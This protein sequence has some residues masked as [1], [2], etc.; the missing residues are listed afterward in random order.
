MSNNYF[1]D[2]KQEHDRF[3]MAQ[4]QKYYTFG[5][6]VSISPTFLKQLLRTKVKR[7]A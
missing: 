1:F 3:S 6:Q 2:S 5:E 4:G 7:A